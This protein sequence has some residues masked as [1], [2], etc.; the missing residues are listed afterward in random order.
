MNRHI[1]GPHTD[2]T[3]GKQFYREEISGPGYKVSIPLECHDQPLWEKIALVTLVGVCS[4]FIA[5]FGTMI[6]HST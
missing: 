4:F 2:P 3:T 1:T 6:I 5:Y